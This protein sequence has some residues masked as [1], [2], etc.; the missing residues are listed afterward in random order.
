MLSQDD[1]IGPAKDI[2]DG[3]LFRKGQLRKEGAVLVR[4]GQT[5][6]ESEGSLV[7]RAEGSMAG[8]L[9]GRLNGCAFSMTVHASPSMVRPQSGLRSGRLST[10]V[11]N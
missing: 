7:S 3:A 11:E 4:I 2:D 9:A 6:Q 5:G 8:L 1:L 10:T